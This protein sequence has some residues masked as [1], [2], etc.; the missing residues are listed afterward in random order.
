[1]KRSISEEKLQS[2]AF[3]VFVV[4]CTL[5]SIYLCVVLPETKNKTF[6]DISQS[7]AKINKV[8]ELSPGQELE[9]VLS[10]KPE[11]EKAPDVRKTESSF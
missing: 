1:M 6:M 5:G 9:L 8:P 10:M 7:F 11:S 3:L 4:V 2:F